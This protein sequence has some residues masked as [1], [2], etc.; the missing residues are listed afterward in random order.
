MIL[1]DNIIND[2]VF[3]FIKNRTCKT[4]YIN[5]VYNKYQDVKAYKIRDEQAF[6]KL[7]H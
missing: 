6:K 3:T 4:I 5:N 1:S 2:S 7:H